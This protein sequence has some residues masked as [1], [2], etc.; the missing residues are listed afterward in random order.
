[1]I[2]Y[3]LSVNRNT[4]TMIYTLLNTRAYRFTFIDT[5]YV[6]ASIKFLGVLLKKLQDLIIIKGYDSYKSRVVIH[7]LEYI[8]MINSQQLTLVLF[9]VLD[10]K[11]HD[12]ILGL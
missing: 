8:L 10:L 7:F 1:M 2:S 6:I 5:Y 9:L 12:L 11:N 4:V 3:N